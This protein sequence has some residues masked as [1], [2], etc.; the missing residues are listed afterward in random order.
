MKKRK[1]KRRNIIRN[2]KN[3]KDNIKKNEC[4]KTER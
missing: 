4:N 3:I 2:E 1:K